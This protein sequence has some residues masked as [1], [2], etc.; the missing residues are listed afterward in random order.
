MEEG[1][2][3]SNSQCKR[4]ESES[5]KKT[6]KCK[7]SKKLK[8]INALEKKNKSSISIKMITKLLSEFHLITMIAP[9]PIKYKL[10]PKV[11]TFM[12]RGAHTAPKKKE[13]EYTMDLIEL[14]KFLRQSSGTT[15]ETQ[16]TS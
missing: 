7:F 2:P 14:L 5:S 1:K 10:K 8:I 4:L 9:K 3:C 15:L 6:C 13:I 12:R 11:T 16:V